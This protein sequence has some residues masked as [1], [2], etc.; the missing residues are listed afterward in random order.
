L[1]EIILLQIRKIKNN[2]LNFTTFV[3]SLLLDSF[4]NDAA[5]RF[6]S[7]KYFPHMKIRSFSLL[8]IIGLVVGCYSCKKD[9]ETEAV[10]GDVQIRV[11]YQT[12]SE[13]TNGAEVYSDPPG[14]SGYTDATGTLLVRGV[15]TGTYEVY[16]YKIGYGG[17][18]AAVSIMEGQ[19]GN[20]LVILIPG[21]DP[22][23]APVID[24]VSPADAS[25]YSP[26]DSVPFRIKVHN[27][28]IAPESLTVKAQSS[29]DGIIFQGHPNSAGVASFS[30]K[31]SKN[32]HT[33]T[34]TVSNAKQFSAH[35]I[36][37]INVTLPDKLHLNTPVIANGTIS[38][39]WTKYTESDFGHYEVYRMS[40]SDTPELLDSFPGV[41]T[42]NYTDADPPLVDSVSYFV[43]VVNQNGLSTSSNIQ[44]VKYPGGFILN[45]NIRGVCIDAAEHC[46]YTLDNYTV[47][48]VNYLTN[49]IMAIGDA[50]IG[51]IPGDVKVTMDIADNG[52]GKELY[53]SYT[54][55]HYIQVFGA[56]N[57]SE[58]ASYEFSNG[59]QD[60]TTDGDG[61]IYI[62][63]KPATIYDYYQVYSLKRT[64][65]QLIDSSYLQY[66]VLATE[67]VPGKDMIVGLGYNTLDN[68]YQ[69]WGGYLGTTYQAH[70]E[71]LQDWQLLPYAFSPDGAFFIT[72]IEGRVYTTDQDLTFT[73]KTITS[74][75]FDD[76]CIA[77]NNV[78]IF[79]AENNLKKV[80]KYKYPS[81]S[82]SSNI[83]T[84]GFPVF[85]RTDGTNLVVLSKPTYSSESSFLL[86]VVSLK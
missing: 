10:K 83:N 30:R 11:Q 29:V 76:I 62:V 73:G 1:P 48:K 63:P 77:P 64:T 14:I 15:V 19:L 44:V 59:L 85:V 28:G 4:P 43:K 21:Y 79:L 17:G 53:V 36:V 65:N 9:K 47:K 51:S 57:L 45:D 13:F 12:L 72:G 71:Y 35:C 24:E 42:T 82:L 25:M 3:A 18:K 39:N 58:K 52:K 69:D 61:F 6:N 74:A 60:F 40:Y 81:I 41:N 78:D 22:G 75:T 5:E 84:K 38:L 55:S 27:A 50:Y 70:P 16:S 8:M 32:Q 66:G 26:G 34:F 86:E 20:T 67:L 49:T 56:A 33:I 23:V 2:F 54:G 31:L 68:I 7:Q 80:M 37:G 46:I